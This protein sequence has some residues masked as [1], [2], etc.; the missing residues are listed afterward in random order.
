[1]AYSR[2][3]R[4]TQEWDAQSLEATAADEATFRPD[5]KADPAAG[6]VVGKATSPHG[7]CGAQVLGSA[8]W[9]RKGGW[10]LVNLVATEQ[11]SMAIPE[12]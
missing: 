3:F 12:R 1:M 4:R 10:H 2:A 11:E 5:G 9:T 7:V 6:L 8:P